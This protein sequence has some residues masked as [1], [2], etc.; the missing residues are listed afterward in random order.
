MSPLKEKTRFDTVGDRGSRR[1][2]VGGWFCRSV[3]PFVVRSLKGI[4]DGGRCR[5]FVRNS[6]FHQ[7]IMRPI[8]NSRALAG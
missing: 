5:E 2:S 8:H 4:R 7:I 3:L 6:S 1:R